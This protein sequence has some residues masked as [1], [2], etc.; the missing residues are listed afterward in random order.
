MVDAKVKKLIDKHEKELIGM[1]VVFN[2]FRAEYESH[3]K[4]GQGKEIELN[5]QN[6][7]IVI[8]T[9]LIE[10]YRKDFNI[11]K[12][13]PTG[14]LPSIKRPAKKHIKKKRK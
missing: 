11:P 2:Q 7:E 10:T 1:T 9:N 12:L 13:K 5:K 3:I 8:K 14:K 4:I 6:A